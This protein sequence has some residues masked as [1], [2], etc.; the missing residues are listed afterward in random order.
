MP[1][2]PNEDTAA[3]RG[4][5]TSG[6]SVRS[7]DSSTAPA[8]QSTW[9]DGSVTCSVFGTTPLRIAMT[10][11]TTPATPAAAWE[12]PIFDLT[13]PSNNGRSRS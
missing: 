4:L 7:V 3:R 11:F 12:C 1:L 8:D 13:D 5:P 6:Q 2:I 9:D 10:I